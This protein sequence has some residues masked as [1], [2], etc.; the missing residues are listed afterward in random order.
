MRIHPPLHAKVLTWFHL[1]QLIGVNS[2][3]RVIVVLCAGCCLGGIGAGGARKAQG[4]SV[5]PCRHDDE[6]EGM[7]QCCVKVSLLRLFR[8]WHDRSSGL[9][10]GGASRAVVGTD[11][12]KVRTAAGKTVPP[13][14]V[15][16]ACAV[17]P[18]VKDLRVAGRT[19]VLTVLA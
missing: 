14:R 19:V 9:V 17:G 4:T 13:E 7:L 10:V 3:G 11:G 18:P 1:D 12:A 16:G 15:L 6:M 5:R 2:T 8:L